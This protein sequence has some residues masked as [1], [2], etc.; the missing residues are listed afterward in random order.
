MQVAVSYTNKS[1]FGEAQRVTHRVDMEML[2]AGSSQDK[3]AVWREPGHSQDCGFSYEG[4]GSRWPV[5]WT[6][7]LSYGIVLNLMC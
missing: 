7:T 4:E 3:A 6:G 1:G 5:H 2:T